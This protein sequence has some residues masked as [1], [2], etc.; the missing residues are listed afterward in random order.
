MFFSPVIVVVAAV[1]TLV[2]VVADDFFPT[3]PPL[4]GQHNYIENFRSKYQYNQLII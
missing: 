3:V 1:V 2:A 4:R